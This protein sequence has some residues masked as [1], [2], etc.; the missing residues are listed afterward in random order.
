MSI[1]GSASP[2]FFQTAAGAGAAAGPIKS[3]RFNSADSANMQRTPSSASNR[4]TWTWAGWVKNAQKSSTRM[5]FAS[6]NSTTWIFFQDNQ[7]YADLNGNRC[8]TNA[9]Y[10]DPSAWYHIVWR[11]DTTQATAADRH[12][13][14]V[15]G[16]L[17]TFSSASYPSQN[18]DTGVNN[19]I[20]H[21]IGAGSSSAYHFDGY[22]ADVYLI[23]GSSLDPTSFGAFDDNGVWQAAAYSGT[24]GTNGFHLFDFANETGVGNDSSGND[25]D[26]SV[27]NITNETAL[28]LPGVDF[29]GSGDHVQSADH[30]DY[31]LGTNDFTMECYIYPRDFDN[32]KAIMMKYTGTRSTSSWWWSLNSSGHILFYLYYGSSEMGIV[33]SGTGMT[34]NEWNHVACVRDGS[35]ARVYINGVQVG[36]GNISTETVND[37]STAVRIG[38]DSQG[39]YDFDG[40]ISNVRLINGTCLYPS[41]TTFTVP[42]T[43]L[44]N[45][46]NTKLLCCQS[47]SSATAATVSPNT[48]S[49]S[50]D[51][52]AVQI[53]DSNASQDVLFDVPTN[54]DSSNDTGAG[55]EVSANYCTL[56][57]LDKATVAVLSD[58]NLRTNSSSTGAIRGTFKYPKTG[59][60]YYE[61]Q[62]IDDAQ[63]N[64]GYFHVGIA[65]ADANLNTNP[66]YD[67]TNEF[68]YWQNGRK[69]NNVGYAASFTAG[70]IIG[71][72]FDADAG[73]LTFY[74]N[75]VSQGV[76]ST[77]LTG[78]YFPYAPTWNYNAAYNFGQRR[79]AY[80]IS[81]YLPLSTTN[82]PTPTIA[83][84]SAH[85]DI[86][87]WTGNGSTQNI[88]GYSFSPDL[89]YTKQ[90]NST[91]FPA[92]FDPIRGVH[93]ALRTHSDGGTYTDNGLLTAFN[94]DGFS[95]GSAGDINSNNNT[96][97]GWAWDAGSSTASNTDGSITTSVRAN[98]TAGFSIVS[99][100]GTGANASI[101]HGLNTA[102]E[103]AIFKARNGTNHWLV[104]HKSIGN[105]KKVN[106]NLND[107]QSS[108]STSFFQSTDPTSSVM[109]LGTESS[110][111]WSGYNM[112]GYLF[113]SVAGY[114]AFGSY[115]GNGSNDGVFV[116][117][118]FS[119]RWLL[120]KASSHGSDWQLWDSARQ[121][122]NVN[123]N[124][125]TP[126]DTIA[127][128]GSAGYAV[129]LLSNGFK[130]R[131]YGSSSNQSN[132]TYVWAAFAS[133]PFQANGGLAR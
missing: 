81:G 72:A 119:V 51:P 99:Y 40:V 102:P 80:P 86:K 91:G 10:R 66:G 132:Y 34:L 64:T 116:H 17:Q 122:Y 103:F 112:I 36:T 19:N 96:Y 6:P 67:T 5:F 121:S 32:Y 43:P 88:T 15:N 90:R 28:S 113:S 27:N 49:T 29:D 44:T 55:G 92:L 20:L 60:W 70:D 62:P 77:G 57:P 47:N 83:D 110:G 39:F 21:V 59:K 89:V 65:T 24:F 95:V 85:F 25:N 2:L 54:G 35:T 23:D 100:T 41:G 79:F 12:R 75:G 46:T 3:V 133:N 118:G 127:E 42:T 11:V 30:A 63:Y 37:S 14:Y 114:S 73:S 45:V 22:L 128:T 117:T 98:Q 107:A 120:T 7:L 16:V 105:D 1:P 101:G 56:N 4:K 111:N 84:G 78:E 58:G 69:T 82:L 131:N 31:S 106:L 61:V 124:T 108:S 53:S 38:E 109:Y 52:Y 94:S 87:L 9:V 129:D 125:L 50:G 126:N 93:N 97:V 13:I 26:F 76:N 74:K 33:T 68:T 130:F 8:I 48:L 18:T 123:A 71:V 104:Y 115:T